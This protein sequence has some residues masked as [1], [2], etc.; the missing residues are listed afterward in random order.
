MQPELFELLEEAKADAPPLRYDVDDV[1]AAGR[2]LR[3]RRTAG[4][5]IAAVVAVA[6]AIGVPQ[7]VTRG[8]ARHIQPA[9]PV[10][11]SPAPGS[12]VTFSYTFRGYDAG[13]YRVSDPRDVD[14]QGV[15]A[16]VRRIG[17]T[18]ETF[19]GATLEAYLPGLDPLAR[20]PKATIT[21]TDPIKGRR[22]FF[23]RAN[24][25]PGVGDDEWFGWEYAD[26]AVAFLRPDP[27]GMPRE[28]LRLVAENFVL[29]PARPVKLP[30]KVG[31]VPSGYRVI[32][33]SGSSVY[34]IPT[35]K[36]IDRMRQPDH[37]PGKHK[38]G[39]PVWNFGINLGNPSVATVERKAKQ[40]CD[41]EGCYY[42]VDGT[43]LQMS[44]GGSVPKAEVEK[45]L[46]SI[47]V[48]DP[49][50]PATWHLVNDALPASA[51]LTHP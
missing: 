12:T 46:A 21:E 26:D 35:A 18:E 10:V 4:W 20:Y 24:E 27:Y 6:A 30:Y 34:M 38:E 9:P 8:S 42:T 7:I 50:D 14:I 28:A 43:D 19:D 47:T 25:M 17:A 22:A 32:S 41:I 31:H 36:A 5:A 33:V 13:G 3:R 1:V 49:A 16:Q 29:T 2:R 23:F 11:T 15:S 39:E 45:T 40:G 37:G 51:L 44:V 48:A